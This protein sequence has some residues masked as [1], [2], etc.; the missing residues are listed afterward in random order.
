MIQLKNRYENK[1]FYWHKKK[2]ISPKNIYPIAKQHSIYTNGDFFFKSIV[3]QLIIVIII[4]YERVRH[5]VKHIEHNNALQM[6]V[7][8]STT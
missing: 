5:W 6:M 7:Q 2:T 3:I 1:L 8:C 4:N